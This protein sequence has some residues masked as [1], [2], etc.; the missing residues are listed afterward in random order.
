ML[1]TLV[2]LL[3][4]RVKLAVLACLIGVFFLWLTWPTIGQLNVESCTPNTAI[5]KLS[6][7]IHGEGF[8]R[9]QLADIR[10]RLDENENWDRIQAENR[11][12][13]SEI[14]EV[15]RRDKVWVAE[16]YGKYPSLAPSPEAQLADRMRERAE[17]IKAE[18]DAVEFERVAQ[19]T[20]RKELPMLQRCE[21]HI[22]EKLRQTARLP[23]RRSRHAPARAE[24]S[25]AGPP[26]RAVCSHGSWRREPRPAA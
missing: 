23:R 2:V 6:A 11:R 25:A 17:Q 4:N 7:L 18:A 15:L 16:I 21:A 13:I 10:H 1:G 9:V 14:D 5:A 26:M 19:E 12:Q 20:M 8:W 22:H 3:N 24:P